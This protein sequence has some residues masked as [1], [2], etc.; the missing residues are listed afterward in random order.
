MEKDFHDKPVKTDI[1][2]CDNIRKI[3]TDLG[4][5]SHSQLFTRLYSFQKLL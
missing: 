3:A 4:D 1:R 5:W 2:T